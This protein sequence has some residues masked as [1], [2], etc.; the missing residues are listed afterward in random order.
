MNLGNGNSTLTSERESD[1][2]ILEDAQ[3]DVSRRERFTERSRDLFWHKITQPGL[4]LQEFTPDFSWDQGLFKS[5]MCC[6]KSRVSLSLHRPHADGAKS[7]HSFNLAGNWCSISTSFPSAPS[8]IWSLGAARHLLLHKAED[9]AKS[10]TVHGHSHPAPKLSLQN[11]QEDA[12][13]TRDLELPYGG[14]WGQRK[15]SDR[16]RDL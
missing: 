7:D 1:H 9:A 12:T 10:P 4:F 3:H 6:T 15:W 14:F 11:Q 8:S 16:V 5:T 13:E 2:V